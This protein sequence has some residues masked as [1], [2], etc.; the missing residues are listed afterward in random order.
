MLCKRCGKELPNGSKF[1]LEC[2]E[3]IDSLE[4][5]ISSNTENTKPI[6]IRKPIYKRISFWII[7]ISFI[8]TSISINI[9]LINSDINTSMKGNIFIGVASEEAE[10]AKQILK[11]CGISN[12]KAATRDE[13]LDV[14]GLKGYR[15]ST[16]LDNIGQVCVYFDHE[17]LRQVRFLSQY[18]YRNQKVEA[19]AQEF[20]INTDEGTKYQISCQNAIKELLKAPSTA[21]FPNITEWK[22]GKENGVVTIQSYVDAQNSFGAMMR[23]DFQFKFKDDKVISLIFDG[24]EYIK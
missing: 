21:K 12:I 22:F 8:I 24:T 17:K 11:E 19:V 1:C 10:N 6:S 13:M 4:E 2:G 5:I 18:L 14:D 3:K 20:Y 9:Q 7:I 15:L 16:E 23:S